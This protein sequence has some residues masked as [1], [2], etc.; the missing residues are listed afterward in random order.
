MFKPI[1]LAG[2]A[3]GLMA[4]GGE[5]IDTQVDGNDRVAPADRATVD[6]VARPGDGEALLT[7]EVRNVQPGAGPVYV[8]VQDR[9]SFATM[10]GD[11]TG[12]AAG[13]TEIV[14]VPITGVEPGDWAVAAFQDLDGNGDLEIAS[15]GPD[16]PYGFSGPIQ[17][18]WPEFELA[19]VEITGNGDRAVVQLK[20]P[21]PDTD[22]VQ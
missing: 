3:L 20:A 22:S 9:A 13:D 16:E 15:N 14:T 7:V 6:R 10:E 19:R 1:L 2:A 18:G 21:V 11:L 12:R 4:C 17:N 5:D 8:V